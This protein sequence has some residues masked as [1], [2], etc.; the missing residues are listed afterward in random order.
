MLRMCKELGFKTNPEKTFQ[1]NKNFI[2]LGIELDS[3][4]QESRID[5]ACQTE[6]L[7]MFNIWSSHKHYTE[8]Q[9]QSLVGKLQLISSVCRLGR[10][11][12]HT[13]NLLT[14]ATHP[15]HL[16]NRCIS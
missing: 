7:H 10:T 15:S 8:Q 16:P 2:L 6:T 12:H 11:F 3:I 14:K 4:A 13:I 1:P 9:L 5:Q